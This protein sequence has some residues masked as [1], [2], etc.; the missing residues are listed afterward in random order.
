MER[1]HDSCGQLNGDDKCSCSA[2]SDDAAGTMN[3]WLVDIFRVLLTVL[4][5]VFLTVHEG[6]FKVL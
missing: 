3:D 6:A 5:T 1:V 4:L 2:L